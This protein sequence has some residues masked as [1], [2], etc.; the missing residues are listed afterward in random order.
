[1]DAVLTRE[2]VIAITGRRRKSA[3]CKWL[4]DNGIKF[5]PNA[6]GH[7]QIGRAYYDQLA[8]SSGRRRGAASEPNWG[9]LPWSK[10]S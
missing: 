6:L 8:G 5:K 1:M 7:P 9:A 4:R 3:Q 10:S 2:E